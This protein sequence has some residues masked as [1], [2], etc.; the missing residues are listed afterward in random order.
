MTNSSS[1]NKSRD[2]T[3]HLFTTGTLIFIL[4]PYL[5]KA[6][7]KPNHSVRNSISQRSLYDDSSPLSLARSLAFS[8]SAN[9]TSLSAPN[10]SKKTNTTHYSQAN[11]HNRKNAKI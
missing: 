9:I 2:Q 3:G 10:Y 6:K 7:L 8:I 4:D 11:L 1:L 5:C